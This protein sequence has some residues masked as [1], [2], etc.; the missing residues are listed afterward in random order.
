M[1][2]VMTRFSSTLWTTLWPGV[3]T[4]GKCQV[5]D[6]SSRGHGPLSSWFLVSLSWELL[7]ELLVRK[8]IVYNVFIIWIVKENCVSK[9]SQKSQILKSNKFWHASVSS[10]IQFLDSNFDPYSFFILAGTASIASEKGGMYVVYV[11]AFLVRI[12]YFLREIKLCQPYLLR[13]NLII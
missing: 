13:R 4:A 6:R 9:R 11:G 7:L 1:L 3:H 12:N 10:S 2:I 5:W 8:Y